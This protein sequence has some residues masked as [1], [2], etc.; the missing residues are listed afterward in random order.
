MY[1][2]KNKIHTN[3]GDKMRI[4]IL[5]RQIREEKGISITQLA[6]LTGMSKG[7]LSRIE[8]GETEPTIL[9]LARISLALN[10][11][12]EKLYKIIN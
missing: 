3:K 5:I 7:H 9:T 4:E 1:V 8:R 12:I 6:K 11:N 10:V 2:I